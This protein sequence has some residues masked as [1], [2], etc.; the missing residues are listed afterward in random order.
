MYR[1]APISTISTFCKSIGLSSYF[2]L[3]SVGYAIP[4]QFI[5]LS[6]VYPMDVHAHCNTFQ[7]AFNTASSQKFC[8]TLLCTAV[9]GLGASISWLTSA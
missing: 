4:K 6:T 2:V 8:H 9:L 7:G 1:A 3:G 5:Y